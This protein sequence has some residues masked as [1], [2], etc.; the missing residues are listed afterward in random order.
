MTP[1]YPINPETQSIGKQHLKTLLPDDKKLSV[2]FRS[3]L[4]LNLHLPQVQDVREFENIRVVQTGGWRVLP[5]RLLKDVYIHSTLSPEILGVVPL[6]TV[7]REL[8]HIINMC[9]K[10]II[11]RGIRPER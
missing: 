10:R 6:R 4:L 11:S 1:L 9:S 8:V 5:L 3:L 7:G 2:Y